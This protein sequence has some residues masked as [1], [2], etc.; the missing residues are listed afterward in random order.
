M[1]KVKQSNLERI[2]NLKIKA[3]AIN[4]D[5][6]INMEKLN[7]Y[8]KDIEYMIKKTSAYDQKLE[9]LI[10]NYKYIKITQKCFRCEKSK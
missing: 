10:A 6:H 2:R 8:E 1:E 4:K 7:F 9:K 5:Y 3:D